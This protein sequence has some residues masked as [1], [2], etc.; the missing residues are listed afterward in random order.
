MLPAI[1]GA[2]EAI[3]QAVNEDFEM[4][5][6]I[7]PI[8]DLDNVKAASSMVDS[9]LSDTYG[10]GL[11]ATLPNYNLYGNNGLG[12]SK[13]TVYNI[14]VALQYEAGTDANLMVNEIAS[15]L[16]SKLDLEG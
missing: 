8:V 1:L 14:S 9:M 2:Q 16:R 7:T 5:P 12:N 10:M 6:I 11:G 4:N 3:A 13:S 15:G